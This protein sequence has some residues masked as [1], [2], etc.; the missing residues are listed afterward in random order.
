MAFFRKKTKSVSM[1][2]RGFP[3]DTNTSRCLLMAAEKEVVVKVRLLDI[4]EGECD[5]HT[6]RAI[7]PF[8]KYPCLVEGES[9]VLGT[10]AIIAYLD[11]RGKGGPLN[12]KKASLYGQQNYWSQVAYE[13]AEPALSILLEEVLC[14][15]LKDSDFKADKSLIQSAKEK[16]QLAFN[17]LEQQLEGK[18]FVIGE[19]SYA[20]IYWTAIVHAFTLVDK[21]AIT[22]MGSNLNKWYERVQTR[23]SFLSLPSLEDVNQKKLKSVA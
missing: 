15:P 9:V 20:D 19:Y 14:G 6:Y 5:Q 16:L 13:I 17:L 23:K 10:D 8:G 12:P 1:E 4:P 3:G 7:S 21:Q 2:L 22:K 18:R 11:V